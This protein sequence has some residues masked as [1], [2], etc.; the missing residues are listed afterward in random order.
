MLGINP[1]EPPRALTGCVLKAAAC[2]PTIEAVT[3]HSLEVSLILVKHL[4]P[5]VVLPQD[6][7]WSSK[8]H[9]CLMCKGKDQVQGPGFKVRLF[10][11][12][13]CLL[14]GDTPTPIRLGIEKLAKHAPG[15][16]PLCQI[17]LH[18]FPVW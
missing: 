12:L 9:L 1:V 7:F 4:V 8:D 16:V 15:A 2:N 5:R 14:A 3:D 17:Q 18:S 10:A 6:L 13:A 11:D